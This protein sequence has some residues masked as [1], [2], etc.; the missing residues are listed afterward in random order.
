M[1]KLQCTPFLFFC[2]FFFF[3]FTKVRLPAQQ[4]LHE[5]SSGRLSGTG[6]KCQFFPHHTGIAQKGC[7]LAQCLARTCP[8]HYLPLYQPTT[9]CLWPLRT[10]LSFSMCSAWWKLKDWTED[11]TA[12]LQGRFDCADWEMFHQMC[13]SFIELTD[14]IS[15]YICYFFLSSTM[16]PP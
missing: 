15:F 16:D 11:S 9:S 13:T 1:C 12:C 10:S 2:E 3:F 7:V 14:V 8:L 5:V 4:L 6:C